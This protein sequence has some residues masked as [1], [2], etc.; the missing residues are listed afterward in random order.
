MFLVSRT[1]TFNVGTC[2]VLSVL[3]RTVADGHVKVHHVVETGA[4]PVLNSGITR[5]TARAP[6]RPVGPT[7]CLKIRENEIIIRYQTV[8]YL[9]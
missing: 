1:C 3:P 4:R 6:R 9:I 5:H 7:N 8:M 2:L